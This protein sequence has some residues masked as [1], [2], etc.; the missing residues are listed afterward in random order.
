MFLSSYLKKNK[1]EIETH[2]N[3]DVEGS[4]DDAKA[5]KGRRTCIQP[6]AHTFTSLISYFFAWIS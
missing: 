3:E 6:T 5:S 4:D 2:C 1:V